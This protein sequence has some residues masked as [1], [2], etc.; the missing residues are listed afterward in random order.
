VWEILHSAGIDPAPRRSGPGWRQFLRA[1]AARIVA[2]DFIHVD[3]VPSASWLG[4]SAERAEIRKSGLWSVQHVTAHH[5]RAFLLR[6]TQL[7]NLQQ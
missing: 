5:E 7:V 6:L 4:L 3:T 1:Q 2:V